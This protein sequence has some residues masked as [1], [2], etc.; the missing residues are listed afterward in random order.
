MAAFVSKIEHWYRKEGG[1]LEGDN[2]E[3]EASG[4]AQRADSS[5]YPAPRREGRIL[6]AMD[7]SR[8]S[9]VMATR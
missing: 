6:R 4:A 7:D 2:G 1:N 3:N 9:P 5:T 8:S